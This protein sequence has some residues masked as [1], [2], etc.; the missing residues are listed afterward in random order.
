MSDPNVQGDYV[1]V[2]ARKAKISKARKGIIGT[3]VLGA[4]IAIT[5]AGSFASFTAQTTNDAAFRT[6]RLE[7]SNSVD[8]AA[9]C[10]SSGVGTSATADAATLDNNDN[11]AC[12]V[13]FDDFVEPGNT[14]T[15]GIDLSNENSNTESILSVYTNGGCVDGI[16]L[17]PNAGSDT[18]CDDIQ[19]TIQTVTDNTYTVVSNAGC[20][21]PAATCNT[22]PGTLD[23]FA[24]ASTGF[25]NADTIDGALGTTAEDPASEHK[26]IVVTMSLPHGTAEAGCTGGLGNLATQELGTDGT[27]CDNV[28]MD[29]TADFDLVWRLVEP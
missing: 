4:V 12:D 3:M 23:G 24:T 18:L 29:R 19:L 15:A 13:L 14:A 17:G 5:G 6:A 11:V 1:L 10:F 25:A 16:N 26:Y 2:P 9:S 20:I 27:G 28:F 8:S 21:Y 22:A 7:L